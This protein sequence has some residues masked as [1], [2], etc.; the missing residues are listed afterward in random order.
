MCLNF[1]TVAAQLET[2]PFHEQD[3][4]VM[5]TMILEPFQ[6]QGMERAS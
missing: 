4:E 1:L 2:I 5:L 3:L 6:Q